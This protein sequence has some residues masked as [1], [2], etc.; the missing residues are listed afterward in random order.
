MQAE[1][2]NY[3]ERELQYLRSLGAEFAAKYPKIAARLLLQNDQ[4]PD[5]HVERLLE[6]F[7]FLT[8]RI[9]H[10]L[11]L[12]FP[13][14]TEAFLSIVYPHYLRPIPSMS[15][16]QF[17]TDPAQGRQTAG[18]RVPR[19][20][21]VMTR[22]AGGVVCRFQTCYETVLWPVRIAEAEWCPPSRIQPAIPASGASAVI[23]LLL[24]CNEGLTFAQ[25]GM[26]SLRIFLDGAGTLVTS[27]YELLFKNCMNVLLRDPAA[28]R[29][30]RTLPASAIR[31]VGFS[32]EEAL[33]P[34]PKRS[35]AGY[36]LLHE[37]FAFPEKFHFMDVELAGAAGGMGR[38]MEVLLPILPFER[39]DRRQMLEDGVKPAAFRTGCSPVVNLFS[40]SADAIRLRRADYEYPI[41]P[42]RRRP[43][44]LD[45]FSVDSVVSQAPGSTD[46]IEYQPLYALRHQESRDSNQ[47]YWYTRRRNSISDPADPGRVWISLVD[48]S[49]RPKLPDT[50]AITVRLTCTNRELPSR[51][52]I[53][54]PQGDF[55]LEGGGLVKRIVAVRKP[56]PSIPTKHRDTVLWRLISQFSLNH[57]SLTNLDALKELLRLYNFSGVDAPDRQV[58]GIQ[59]I[60]ATPHFARVRTAHGF[61]FAKGHLLELEL[62]EDQFVGSGV[63]LFAAILERFFGMYVSLNSFTQLR[64]R[65]PQRKEVVHTWPPRSGRK[66]LV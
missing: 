48:L 42:D 15:V 16:V 3:Y 22:P 52:P 1:F 40:Q 39:E 66:T 31:P 25:L 23:R 2:L 44:A 50:D 43:N 27:L 54:N 26:N 10:K 5:P 62:D 12:D 56:T 53:G 8:S 18:Y 11:D 63:F 38:Q 46:L 6:G 60:A 49:A 64:L 45:V 35:F 24:E 14:I 30:L 9:H 65:T 37:Y 51:L 34:Y 4:Q 7:A 32:E 57:L 61:S 20:A 36:R 28:P 47:T 58:D 13:E 33:L 19:G 29:Q 21:T 59:A 55:E 17:L 41:V